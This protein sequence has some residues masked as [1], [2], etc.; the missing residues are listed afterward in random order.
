[1]DYPKDIIDFAMQNYQFAG[2]VMN[3]VEKGLK[4]GD[5][6]K[7]VLKNLEGDFE[8]YNESLTN[9]IKGMLTEVFNEV[10]N[11]GVFSVYL[12][13]NLVAKVT[14]S[15]INISGSEALLIDKITIEDNHK[16]IKTIS[17]I[18]NLIISRNPEIKQFVVT[19]HP[20]VVNMVFDG[21]NW[22]KVGFTRLNDDLLIKKIQ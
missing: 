5:S 18:T 2:T 4:K 7:A 13:E 8:Y 1:M 9:T 22:E 3:A 16:S 17:D 12:D 11:G 14:T 21:V 20:G 19:P 15:I 10:A 6:R